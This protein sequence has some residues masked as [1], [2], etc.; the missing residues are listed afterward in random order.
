VVHELLLLHLLVHVLFLSHHTYWCLSAASDW[1][2][3][4]SARLSSGSDWRWDAHTQRTWGNRD[5]R[6]CLTV[7]ESIGLNLE[8]VVCVDAHGRDP[9]VDDLWLIGAFPLADGDGVLNVLE[10]AELFEDDHIQQPVVH[11]RLG[12]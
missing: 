3:L 4:A 12:D 6:W 5:R 10:L 7:R 8:W 11:Q 2:N 1:L 9:A